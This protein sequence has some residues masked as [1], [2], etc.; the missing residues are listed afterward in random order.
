V[1]TGLDQAKRNAPNATYV[2]LTDADIAYQAYH[3]HSYP[4]SVSRS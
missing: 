3:G 4:G 1:A 2:L